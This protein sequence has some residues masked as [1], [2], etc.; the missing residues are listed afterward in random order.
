MNLLITICARGGSKG[1]PG[2]NIKELDGKP[3]LAYTISVAQKFSRKFETDIELS[4]DSE[5]I[6]RIAKNYGLETEYRR[7]KELASDT[8]GKVTAIEDLLRYK[9]AKENKKYDIILDLDVTSPLRTVEDLTNALKKLQQKSNA[10]NI[11]SVSPAER[12]PYFNM[13]E[14]LEDGF[15]QLV[16]KG[17]EIKSR[18]KAPE[19][20]DMNASFY[21]FKRN[22]FEQNYSITVTDRSLGYVVPHICFDIDKPL[23]FKFMD[24]LL[25][26]N[27][28]DFEI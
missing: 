28:M 8:A 26:E 20:Y 6:I 15:V 9:E 16:K 24:F 7:P 3:V 18:Q 10:L 21:F 5:D 23:D 12:N 14:E 27:L 2:K 11:F 13:V 22:Y 4:T 1:I 25:R 17:K 19:V